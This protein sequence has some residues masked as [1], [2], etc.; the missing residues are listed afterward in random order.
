V[1]GERNSMGSAGLN[2]LLL[3]WEEMQTIALGGKE[4]IVPDE[5]SNPVRI[6]FKNL[7]REDLIWS[8][9]LLEN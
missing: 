3:V 6:F 8:T 2:E 7:S 5:V 4:K 9:G 1:G